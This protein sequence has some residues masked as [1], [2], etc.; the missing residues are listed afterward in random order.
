MLKRRIPCY[1]FKTYKRK[2]VD[3]ALDN[4]LNLKNKQI[5][6]FI[7]GEGSEFNRLKSKYEI[8]KSQISFLGY[9]KMKIFSIIML[10][11]NI[12]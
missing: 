2:N 9:L 6:I 5:K 10:K 1:I 4:L 7:L 11:Q 8:N 12:S 3:L